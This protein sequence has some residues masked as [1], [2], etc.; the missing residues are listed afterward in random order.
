MVKCSTC[1]Y[2]G[3]WNRETQ[4]FIVAPKVSRQDGSPP[5][6]LNGNC[7]CDPTLLCAVGAA[8]LQPTALNDDRDCS[9]F[10]TWIPG[11]SAKDHFDVDFLARQREEARL[12]EE[13]RK[14]WLDR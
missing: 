6:N 11:L 14:A 1:G 8:D 10:I 2:L 5:R 4:L 12:N 9:R 7:L 3:F 13:A